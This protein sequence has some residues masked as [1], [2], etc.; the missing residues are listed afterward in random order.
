MLSLMLSLD[1]LEKYATMWTVCLFFDELVSRVPLKVNNKSCRLPPLPLL[2]TV[3]RGVLMFVSFIIH[4]HRLADD[5]GG[6]GT[7]WSQREDQLFLSD[8]WM[9]CGRRL[10]VRLYR[11][12]CWLTFPISTRQHEGILLASCWSAQN[13]HR[14][15]DTSA[16]IWA[17]ILS[18]V[19]STQF[20]FL[21]NYSK[22]HIYI[23]RSWSFS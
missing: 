9:C 13:P 5:G 14:L 12:R 6:A 1:L 23:H 15:S 3:F 21:V 20:F 10:V 17:L 19:A 11:P 22:Q 4:K 2:V 7:V 18:R 8:W 16:G